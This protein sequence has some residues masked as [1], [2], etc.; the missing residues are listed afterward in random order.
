MR[1]RRNGRTGRC[2]NSRIIALRSKIISCAFLD[3]TEEAPDWLSRLL[4]LQPGLAIAGVKASVAVAFAPEV[5][6]LY[7]DG[8][9]KARVPEG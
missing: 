7:V 9:R 1:K 3:R 8:L 5:L 6:E 2:A 4:A